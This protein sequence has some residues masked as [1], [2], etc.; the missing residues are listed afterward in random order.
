MAS[1]KVIFDPLLLHEVTD[2][3]KMSRADLAK[4]AGVS[5]RTIATAY[6]GEAVTRTTG[7]RIAKALETIVDHLQTTQSRADRVIVSDLPSLINDLSRCNT[8]REVLLELEK[9][10]SNYGIRRLRY[11]RYDDRGITTSDRRLVGVESIGHTLE[12][13]KEF[14]LGRL[15]RS[16]SS[17]SFKDPEAFRAIDTNQPVLF[18]VMAS[19][20]STNRNTVPPEDFAEVEL[21]EDPCE[22]WLTDRGPPPFRWID[23]PLRSGGGV[24]GKLSADLSEIV[25]ARDAVRFQDLASLAAG[26]L[27]SIEWNGHIDFQASNQRFR[28]IQRDLES[29]QTLQ[30]FYHYC[31]NTLCDRFQCK[32]ASFFTVLEDSLGQEQLVLRNSSFPK[33]QPEEDRFAYNLSSRKENSLTAWAARNRRVL[34]LHHLNIPEQIEPQLE[35]YGCD[36][37]FERDTDTSPTLRDSTTHDSYLAVPIVIGDRLLGVVRFTERTISEAGEYFTIDDERELNH[38]VTSVVAPRLDMLIKIELVRRLTELSKKSRSLPR[39]PSFE[40]HADALQ[41]LFPEAPLGRRLYLANKIHE[42]GLHATIMHQRGRLP[43]VTAS[44]V[45][46]IDIEIRHEYPAD[47]F[48]LPGSLTGRAWLTGEPFFIADKDF[49]ESQDALRQIATN[50]KCAMACRMIKPRDPGAPNNAVAPT[51]TV[52]VIE[53]ERFDLSLSIDGALLKAYC[54]MDLPETPNYAI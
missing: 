25:A 47:S 30:D 2:A 49:A 7:L 15:W 35:A 4:R 6:A 17:T 22:H 53:S 3:K 14:R 8:F 31:T 32:Y 1:Q 36:A 23:F 26:F 37:K 44:L 28:D 24:R 21:R 38:L 18:T 45:D 13:A 48:R 16:R 10:L 50:A 29:I 42:D 40:Q 41:I 52:L 34:R 9:R 12:V 43:C 51:G 27:D 33:C 46:D 5:L 19:S 11:Y 54:Q 20:R 39:D